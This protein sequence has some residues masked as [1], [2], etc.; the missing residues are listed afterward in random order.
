MRRELGH[1]DDLPGGRP[2]RVL[3][4][5]LLH[6]AT[7]GFKGAGVPLFACETADVVLRVLLELALAMRTTTRMEDL[8]SKLDLNS[9]IQRL[10]RQA[11]RADLETSH[12]PKMFLR[13]G[14]ELLL[15]PLAAE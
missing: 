5:D 7:G 1:R 8:A 2:V 9:Q 15:A 14:G 6:C 11:D 3:S 10:F 13:I 12:F 4:H